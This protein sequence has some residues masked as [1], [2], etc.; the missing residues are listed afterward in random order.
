MRVA[1]IA[2]LLTAM[3]L[4]PAV[5]ADKLTI[6]SWGGGYSESLRKAFYEPFAKK[7]GISIVEDEWDGN[8]ASI[9]GQV[10]TKTYKW[11]L[12][13]GGSDN[14]VAGCDE[15]VLERLDYAKAGVKPDDF[16]PGI[17]ADC[18]IPVYV[19]SQQFGY[20]ATKLPGEKPST[21]A[22]FWNLTKFPGKRGLY[23]RAQY[24]LEFALMADGVAPADVYKV[25]S[26]PEGVDRAFKKLDE[27]KPSIVWSETGSVTT[28]LLVSGEVSMA[29]VSNGRIYTAITKEKQPVGVFWDHQIVDVDYWVVPKGAPN[30]DKIYEYLTFVSTKEQ[31]AETSKYT[32]F[33]PTR[34]GAEQLA[35]E[36]IRKNLPTAPENMMNALK[37]DPQFWADNKDSLQQRFVNWLNN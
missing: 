34:V 36:E 5:A 37:L 26:T 6:T 7:T 11:S 30:L 12:I 3:T 10:E 25:L 33:G 2:C 14:Q 24:N 13:T 17:A 4:A 27:I 29:V 9:A 15:G 32:T 31:Q 20:N 23:K 21:I 1:S 35:P 22:D 8:N 18:G 16:Q 28:Q 19:Y